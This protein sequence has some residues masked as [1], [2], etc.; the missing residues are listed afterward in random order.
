MNTAIVPFGNKGIFLACILLVS[1]LSGGCST[2]SEHNARA[3]GTSGKSASSSA[4]SSIFAT[5]LE[6]ERA[7]EAEVFYR[8][9]SGIEKP[10]S[11]VID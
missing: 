3:L 5:K 10:D 6:Y 11:L 8:S 4:L 1:A 2:I 7:M 9:S